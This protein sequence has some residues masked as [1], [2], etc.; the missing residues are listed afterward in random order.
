MDITFKLIKMLW[1]E[2]KY[3]FK[4]YILFKFKL[5]IFELI[6]N[7][8]LLIIMAIQIIVY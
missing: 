2:N 7:I 6:Y 1:K 4:L 3:K 5:M 8:L